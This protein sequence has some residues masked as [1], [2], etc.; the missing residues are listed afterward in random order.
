[1]SGALYILVADPLDRF[2]KS[3][4]APTAPSQLFGFARGLAM[5]S[6]DIYKALPEFIEGPRSLGTLSGLLVH[7]RKTAVILLH[8]FEIGLVPQKCLDH[9]RGILILR[10]DKK[11]KSLGIQ[12]GS[13]ES[14][15][16]WSLPAAES[17]CRARRIR[18]LGLGFFREAF[19]PSFLVH[20][21]TVLGDAE[22][23]ITARSC[24]TSFYAQAVRVY[25]LILVMSTQVPL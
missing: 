14:E 4:L 9:G 12:I 24:T 7:P 3:P 8:N 5:F 2:P 20:C 16:S 15:A 11:G 17:I 18:A 10:A 23:D 25:V 21:E 22:Y 6:I 19:F 13:E 1:M